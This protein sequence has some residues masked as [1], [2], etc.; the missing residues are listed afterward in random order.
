MLKTYAK[1]ITPKALWMPLSNSYWWWINRGTHQLA[2]LLR[3]QRRKSVRILRSYR[4]LHAGERCF[5]LGNGPSLRDTDLS[6][7]RD[8]ITFGMNRIYLLFL[9]MGY[10]T[11]YYLAINTLVVEQ[12]GMDI[13]S[14]SMPKFITWRARNWV[15]LGEN[16]A[17]IDSDFTPPASFATDC[18]GRI[19]EGSTVTYVAMQ[20]AFY[21]G[22]QKVILVG[23]DHSF[24][25]KGPPNAVVAAGEVDSDHF[26]PDYFSKG[27]RW[28]LP[29]LEASEEA[30]KLAK[31]TFEKSGRQILDAT[32]GGKLTIFPKVD[33][34]GLFP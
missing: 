34:Q 30:Y 27:Y 33:Y 9:E 20:L 8:E 32:I 24:H 25:T 13:E 29:D 18:T 2:G 31:I 19:F 12:S 16:S 3:S 26:S 15:E 14:L 6:L 21:M 4:N 17:F 7:L 22:F 10:Q 28:Q 1:K 5:I 23:V 11:T